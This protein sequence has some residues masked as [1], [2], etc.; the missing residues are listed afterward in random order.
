MPK[1]QVYSAPD[2]IN[3]EIM[4]D[5]LQSFG[6]AAEVHGYYLWSGI[7]QLPP[8]VYPTVWVQHLSQ[9]QEARQLVKRFEAGAT[10]DGSIWTCPRCQEEL[11]PQFDTCWRCGATRKP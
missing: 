6:I 7:G 3:A 2:P 1:H 10:G 5:Y 9:R 4:K 8:D 11:E